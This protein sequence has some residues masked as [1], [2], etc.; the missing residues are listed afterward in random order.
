MVLEEKARLLIFTQE[1]Q[2]CDIRKQ[3]DYF[4]ITFSKGC[5]RT[6]TIKIPRHEGTSTLGYLL[7]NYGDAPVGSSI[8]RMFSDNY[9]LLRC[10]LRNN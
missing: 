6:T 2:I 8:S 4:F 7:D 10:M 3:N 9:T 1:L 5:F